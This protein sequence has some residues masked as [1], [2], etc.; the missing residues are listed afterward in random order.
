MAEVMTP[1]PP[2]IG[3]PHRPT[4]L[5]RLTAG[6]LFGEHMPV[7]ALADETCRALATRLAVHGL[8]RL[9]VVSDAST[10]RLTGIVSRSDLIKPALARRP[11]NGTAAPEKKAQVSSASLR[12]KCM[13]CGW[14]TSTHC[15]P[16]RLQWSCTRQ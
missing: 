8:E 13:A 12:T 15:L 1:S 5:Q 10:L 3:V 11:R 4:L 6:D 2:S 9:R 16:V 14:S 7:V